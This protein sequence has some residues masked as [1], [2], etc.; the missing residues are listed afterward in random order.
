M[1]TIRSVPTDP[2]PGSRT[3]AQIEADIERTRLRLAGT[4]DAIAD[5]VKPANVARRTADSAKSVV[6][7]EDGYP[8][9]ARIAALGLGAAALAAL[10]VW[11][12][13]R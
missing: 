3:P 6:V 5:R 7:D 9:V 10:F 2:K 13:R 11:R 1:S 8:R 12:R 4:V